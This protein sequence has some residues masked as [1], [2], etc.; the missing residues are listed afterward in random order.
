MNKQLLEK[1]SD[2]RNQW[3][4]DP[5]LCCKEVLGIG[6]Q[7]KDSTEPPIKLDPL[8][9][10]IIVEMWELIRMKE[11]KS[12][13]GVDKLTEKEKFIAEKIGVSVQSGKGV[14]KTALASIVALLFLV[15]FRYARV[16]I[17]GP[18]YDQIKANLWPEIK[19][20]FAHSVEVYGEDSLLN[21]LFKDQ[22]DLIY[23]THVK[24]VELKD[25]WRIFIQTFPKNSDIATQ[26]SSVQGN[27]DDYM[28]FL[29][30]EASGIPD[31]I[32]EPIE[33]TLSGIVNLVFAI[34]NPN[35]NTGW[36]IETQG[37]MKEKWV[38]AHIDAR[39][40]TLVTEEHIQYMLYKYG[41]DSNKFRVSVLGL[42]PLAEEGCLISW[43]WIQSAKD[44][45]EDMNVAETEPY[46]LGADI[47]GG[48][49]ASM[50]CRRQ[51]MKVMKFEGNKSV[52]TDIV[53]NWINRIILDEEPDCSYVD[54]NGIGN[55]TYYRLQSVFGKKKVKGINVRKKAF[56]INKFVML[57][58]ELMWRLR[59]VFESGEIAIPPN[60]DELEGE[61]SLLKY[62]DDGTDGKIKVISKQNAEYKREMMGLVGYKSPNKVDSLIMTFYENYT[63]VLLKTEYKRQGF[64]KRLSALSKSGNW[65]SR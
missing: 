14:G 21:Q 10:Q 34:F 43:E 3:I 25:R 35:K 28:L 41:A 56:N 24:P 30:D 4:F 39:K 61:L 2:K 15:C 44:R 22:N 46:L 53:A 8:Q 64:R 60:D 38:T 63:S 31:H 45:W 17:L 13:I 49:D 37:K 40:S 42:P 57:R 1:L 52:D 6:V 54:M 9:E 55:T 7:K 48:G 19:K 47:G 59:E 32:F 11:K 65:M 62:D 50:I 18:K 23:C 16:V 5:L 36:A 20:W 12:F 29:M 51:G 26:Q 58:D 27:H 33:S